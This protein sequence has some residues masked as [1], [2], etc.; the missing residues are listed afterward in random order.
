MTLRRMA[1]AG[2]GHDGYQVSKIARVAN[3]RVDALIS[4]HANHDQKT[5]SKIS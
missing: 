2:I 1:G 5:D 3:R 4:K